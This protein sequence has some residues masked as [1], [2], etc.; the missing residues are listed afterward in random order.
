M[1]GSQVL[2][3]WLLCQAVAIGKPG[4]SWGHSGKV[5]RSKFRSFQ[6]RPPCISHLPPGK[7]PEVLNSR[8]KLPCLGDR[9]GRCV[10]GWEDGTGRAPQSELQGCCSS[11]R[12]AGDTEAGRL[13]GGQDPPPGHWAPALWL[14][15]PLCQ[16]PPRL[17]SCPPQPW[18]REDSRDHGAQRLHEAHPARS[19]AH[20]TERRLR[21]RQVPRPR[22][23]AP[24]CQNPQQ[25]VS[26][27]SPCPPPAA[28]LP[29]L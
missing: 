25:P 4:S 7:C 24:R 6:A 18:P 15:Q 20:F 27:P 12:P 1:R 23:P 9:D 8:R 11:I 10:T 19:C 21:L 29:I 13:G 22:L 28:S 2:R 5:V 16:T 26:G 14:P 17:L 3:R